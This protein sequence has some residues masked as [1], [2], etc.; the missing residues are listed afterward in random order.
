MKLSLD[1]QYGVPKRGL[2]LKRDFL[3]WIEACLQA[4]VPGREKTS[5]SLRIVDSHEM[6]QL[7]AAYRQKDKPTN[8]L[9]FPAGIPDGFPIPLLG[10]IVLCDEVIRKESM[11]QGKAT[12]AHWAHLTIHGTLHLLGYDHVAEADATEMEAL[13][14]KILQGLHYPSPY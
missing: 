4:G 3:R 2:P 11:E 7:N 14:T 12:E 5:I 9:S 10:D 1:I 8:V 13:E 6:Q